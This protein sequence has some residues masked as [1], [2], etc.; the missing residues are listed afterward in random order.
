M[1]L[2]SNTSSDVDC[3]L[4]S[5]PP[6]GGPSINPA[7]KGLYEATSHEL[8]PEK[9]IAT[10]CGAGSSQSDIVYINAVMP[11]DVQQ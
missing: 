3:A 1:S 9:S 4:L 6:D 8:L 7:T 2:T 10:N 11:G 5:L